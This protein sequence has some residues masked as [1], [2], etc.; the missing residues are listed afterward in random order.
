M[1]QLLIAH[2]I[3]DLVSG[4]RVCPNAASEPVGKF[5]A[6]P[7]NQTEIEAAKTKLDEFED[8]CS[9]AAC[10][11]SEYISDS[12]ILFV[13]CVLKDP[14]ATWDK[15]QQKFARRSEMGQQTAQMALLHFQHMV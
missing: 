2:S 13:A 10:L 8:A 11:I 9:K 7:I 1:K 12:E 14:V 5:G 3:W 15:L 6:P 4:K